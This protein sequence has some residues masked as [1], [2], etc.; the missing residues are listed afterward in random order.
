[1]AAVPKRAISTAAFIELVNVIDRRVGADLVPVG[2]H[3]GS[4]NRAGAFTIE[5]AQWA[6]H[7][8]AHLRHRPP[9]RRTQ[10]RRLLF[11]RTAEINGE[12]LLL[13]GD[14]FAQTDVIYAI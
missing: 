7:A 1:V 6:R 9:P 12:P 8:K 2:S 13:K 3:S 5:Q 14:D 11:I 10:L 4:E